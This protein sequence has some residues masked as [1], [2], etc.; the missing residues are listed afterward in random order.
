MRITA[1][2]T[3][4]PARLLRRGALHVATLAFVLVAFIA[5]PWSTSLAS[6]SSTKQSITHACGLISDALADGPDPDVDPL[7][8]ALA[9][10][11]PL[12]A[13]KTSDAALE[14]AIKRLSSAYAT[15]YK[16]K[17]K[18]LPSPLVRAANKQVEKYCPGATS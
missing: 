13:I 1:P 11:R 4:S 8:Y 12:A 17:G 3:T 2:T 9:Q 16:D 14:K 5:T 10:I 18:K 7:G 15:F 6:A